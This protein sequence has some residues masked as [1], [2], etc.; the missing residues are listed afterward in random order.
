MVMRFASSSRL[1]RRTVSDPGDETLSHHRS[2]G[3][4]LAISTRSR[5]AS[6][7]KA[8]SPVLVSQIWSTEIDTIDP[9]YYT[10]ADADGQTKV[11]RPER[12]VLICWLTVYPLPADL[13]PVAFVLALPSFRIAAQRFFC[14]AA[15]AARP[16][17]EMPLRFTARF[18]WVASDAL[19]SFFFRRPAQYFFI[20]TLTDRRSAAVISRRPRREPSCDV[21]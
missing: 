19:V 9:A 18:G 5:P 4:R 15:I 16:A 21:V 10:L 1:M 13:F 7:R 14:A 12:A 6:G 3:R 2:V 8:G 11:A 20:L 17:A